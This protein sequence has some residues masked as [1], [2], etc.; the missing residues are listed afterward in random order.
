M[1][2]LRSFILYQNFPLGRIQGSSFCRVLVS[3]MMKDGTVLLY[4]SGRNS[5]AASN[6]D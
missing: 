5:H 4:L 1:V 6:I 2:A 3:V